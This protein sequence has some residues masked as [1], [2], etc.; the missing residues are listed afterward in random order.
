M[1]A[2]EHKVAEAP[3]SLPLL[4]HAGAFQRD[5][6]RFLAAL[7]R[8]GDLVRIRMG[9][10]RVL[11]VCHPA[12]LDEMLVRDK[13]F[14]RTG[15]L[16]QR[17]RDVVGNGVA[18]CPHAEH[19]RQRRLVQPAFHKSRMPGYAEI[20]S[21]QIAEH[22]GAWRD[23]HPMNVIAELNRLTCAVVARTLFST[24]LEATELARVVADIQTVLDGLTRSAMTPPAVENFPIVG[25]RA[26]LC[27]RDRL[28]QGTL[29]LV[30]DYRR[31]GGDRGDLISMLLL[32][33]D[34]EDG[35]LSDEEICDQ[36]LT[37]TMAGTETLAN[38]LAWALHLLGQHPEVE[39]R[40][41]AEVDAVLDG[42]VAT[43][44]DLDR[45]EYTGR[46]IAET[47]RLHS[48]AFLFLRR[49]STDTELG[50]TPIPEGATVLWSPHTIHYRRDLYPDPERFDPDRWSGDMRKTLPRSSY[51][52]FGGG[53]RKCVGEHFALTEGTMALASIVARWR[54]RP[55]S[56]RPVR[57]VYRATLRPQLLRM[58][59][60]RR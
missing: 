49:V 27:A 37:F 10:M 39:R 31:V 40:L 53:P 20:A 36:I 50:G 46:V 2:V 29:R 55:T 11:V 51:V 56:N 18:T 26:F 28:R 44:A 14:D 35:R 1:T 19:R 3:G 47:L 8:H 45:L 54:L 16:F 57:G 41:H 34:I 59:P 38:T 13:I 12:L 9:P 24:E 22:M 42:R 23:G 30:S 15:P 33:G 48:P 7:S 43:F 32:A 60:E 21:R 5:P 25:I 4:G 17:A 6:A 52:P 58:T